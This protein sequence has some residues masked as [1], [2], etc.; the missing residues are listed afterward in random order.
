MS[1]HLPFIQ[2]FL[3]KLDSIVHLGAEDKKAIGGLPIRITNFRADQDVVREGDRT[4]R[5]CILLEGVACSFKF[6]G[7]GKRQISAFHFPGDCPDMQSL[8]L[9]VLDS[10]VGT[11]SPCVVGFVEHEAIRRLCD[12]HP[13]IA[14]T[15]WRTTLIDAAVFREWVTN[16]GQR[17]AFRRTAHLFCEVIVRL[18]AVGLVNGD[19]L[20]FPITQSELGEATGLSTVHVNR[21]LKGLRA[22]Q[23][24]SWNGSTLKVL[25]WAGLKEAG[26]FD[27]TY[28]HLRTMTEATTE[29]VQLGSFADPAS[30]QWDHR[31]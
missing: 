24:L 18:R 5:S 11:L 23:L 16:L 28:L 30:L 25:D 13:T 8:H 10:S 22:K 17:Q 2:I 19:S 29:R 7:E 3:R 12:D 27:Q 26:D 21:M 31:E 1:P 6:T 9:E 4:S 15:F 20:D 14:A